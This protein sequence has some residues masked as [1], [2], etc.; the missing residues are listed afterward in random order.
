MKGYDNNTCRAARALCLIIILWMPAGRAAAQSSLF[1]PLTISAGELNQEQA[2]RY[3]K[4]L[5]QQM[6]RNYQFVH[7]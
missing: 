5:A 2:A 3:N 1:T 7:T 4:V 6:H